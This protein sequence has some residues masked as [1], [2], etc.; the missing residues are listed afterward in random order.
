VRSGSRKKTPQ[1]K[2]R[3]S[4]DR[5]RRNSFSE[6]PHKSI[7][8]RKRLRNRANRHAEET[9]LPSQPSPFDEGTADDIDT[10]MHHK[11]PHVWKKC[12]D[13]PLREMIAKNQWRRSMSKRER[14]R[15]LN[16]LSKDV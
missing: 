11:A 12:P 3:L 13:A 1:E 5:D 8:L 2:K 9:H 14:L 4:L 6:A 7:Q 10:G 15:L 16:P